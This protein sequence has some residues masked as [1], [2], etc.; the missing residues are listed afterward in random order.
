MMLP[1]GS[2]R[3]LDPNWIMEGLL[4][5]RARFHEAPVKR[6]WRGHLDE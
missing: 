3:L 2:A 1:A 5:T 6:L 4:V